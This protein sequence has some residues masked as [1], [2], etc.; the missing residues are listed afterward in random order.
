MGC[1]NRSAGRSWLIYEEPRILSDLSCV[2]PASARLNR[3]PRSSRSVY[4]GFLIL[5]QIVP[6]V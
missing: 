5:N 6:V 3:L 4:R 1:P 2:I